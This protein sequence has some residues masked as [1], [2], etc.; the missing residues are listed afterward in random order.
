MNSL[1]ESMSGPIPNVQKLILATM[2][3]AT[4]TSLL[5]LGGNTAQ[6]ATVQVQIAL[7]NDSHFTP[8]IL[9]IHPG[10]TV[11]WVWSDHQDHSVVSG[12]GNT[13]AADGVFNSGVHSKPFTYS[14]T[15]PNEGDFPYF[16]GV[17]RHLNVGGTWPVVSVTAATPALA[18]APT[19]FSDLNQDSKP[20][21]VLYN[22][23][24]R[25]TAIW[26]LNNNIYVS[27]AY[28][29]TLPTGWELAGVADFNGD[30]KLDYLL[31]NAGTRQTAIWYLSGAIFVSSVYGPSL[32]SNWQLIVVVDLNQDSNPDYVLYN[33]ST[34][35]TAIWYLNNNV[36]VSGAYGP[37]LPAGWSVAG[38]ADF[39]GD[40][41]LDYLLFNAGTRQTAIWYLSGASLISGA[42]GPTVASGY[43]LMGAADFN[44]NSKPDYGLYNSSTRQTALWYLNNNVLSG[45]AWGPTLP[46]GWSLAPSP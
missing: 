35:Q 2:V 22:A 12:N 33:A 8:K 11:Q 26:Y 1:D 46:A 37:T 27:G 6:A 13:G 45:S 42:Y 44:G 10:D 32:P 14:H 39:D 36:Y 31:F 18:T 43:S 29:P 21:Y 7:G 24:T 9:T 34:R 28:G 38:I 15:F 17:H 23:G 30:G 41:K 5:L 25:Q 3:F 16:C 40:R 20:D 19:P 4:L